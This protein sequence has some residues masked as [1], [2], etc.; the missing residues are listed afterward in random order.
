MGD[1]AN[2]L[3][4]NVDMQSLLS[5]LCNSDSTHRLF[6]AVAIGNIAS[7]LDLQE[8]VL[9]GGALQPLIGLS[10]NN[11]SDVE[12][13]RCVAYAICNLSSDHPNR[14]SIILNGGLASI[15]FLCHTGDTAD[16][17]A[18][19]STLRGLAA[20]AEARRPIV[21]EGVLCVLA[22]AAVKRTADHHLDL[23]WRRV[24]EAM[25]IRG[26]AGVP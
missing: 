16:M 13:Q 23:Q 9:K 22:L 4:K 21:E 2:T 26:L 8:P 7:H 12:S 5:F 19:L 18:A 24:P 6:G 1:N 10:D 3:L 25:I 11:T 15:M 14:M 20:S 17:L